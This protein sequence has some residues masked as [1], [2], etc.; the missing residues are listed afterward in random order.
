MDRPDF[1]WLRSIVVPSVNL[2]ALICLP[3]PRV[4][5]S[6]PEAVRSRERRARARAAR[7]VGFPV[8]QR[9]RSYIGKYKKRPGPL[10]IRVY[11][12]SS[13][14]VSHFLSAP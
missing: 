10:A 14:F 1:D 8:P 7:S 4:L 2:F 3:S 13:V 6:N 11:L 5:S 9:P 12:Q